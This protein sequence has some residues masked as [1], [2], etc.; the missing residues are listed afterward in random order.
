VTY[1]DAQTLDKGGSGHQRALRAV[2]PPGEDRD[3]PRDVSERAAELQLSDPGDGLDRQYVPPVAVEWQ[4]S[5]LF[6]SVTRS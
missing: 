4:V 3:V 5:L 6:Q 1:S 2:R